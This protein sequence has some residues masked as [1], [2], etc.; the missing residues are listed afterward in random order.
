M[1]NYALAQ[2]TDGINLM[3]SKGGASAKSLF[4]LVN[5]Y[6]SPKGTI[7]ARPG[8]PKYDAIPNSAGFP[9]KGLV[10]SVA[11]SGGVYATFLHAPFSYSDA[12]AALKVLR[13][14]S[15]TTAKLVE[16][17]AAFPFLSRLYVVAEFDDGVVQH[18][19]L[20]EPSQWTA[21]TV[22]S[23]GSRV[24]ALAVGFGAKNG[25]YYRAT[26]VDTTIAWTASTVKTVG[27]FVQPTVSNGFK[28][29]ATAVS[30]TAPILTSNSEPVWPTTDGATVIER[31]YAGET[32][33]DPGAT[34]PPVPTRPTGK[35]GDYGP[36]S[37]NGT[38]PRTF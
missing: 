9:T 30:G 26:N 34:T 12:K 25:F 1:R 20:D 15:S 14:P 31:R 17:H 16:I 3:R 33:A 32:P 38:A 7:N 21:S 27:A 8:A 4:D 2:Q 29:E 6:I 10:A 5:G 11:S 37:P 24:R 13:H 23:Y 36:Y 18:Y 28:Y 22:Y 35:P 19:W